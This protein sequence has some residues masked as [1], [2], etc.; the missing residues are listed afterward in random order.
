M[1]L[2]V[3]VLLYKMYSIVHC[4]YNLF[5]LHLM[6]TVAMV[7]YRQYT[8]TYTWSS[9][10]DFQPSHDQCSWEVTV[11]VAWTMSLQQENKKLKLLMIINRF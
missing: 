9:C 5:V 3:I 1:K 11:I 4:I 2:H 6:L 8:K 7:T 10:G